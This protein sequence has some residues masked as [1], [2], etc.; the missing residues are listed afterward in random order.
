M[1]K[2]LVSLAGRSLLDW[3]LDALTAA[4]M[5]EI[6][7][8]VGYRGEAVER[9]GLARLWNRSWERSNMVASLLVAADWAGSASCVVSYGDIVYHPGHVDRLAAAP[10]DIAITC[11]LRWRSL[12]EE[13]FARPEE[14]A[15]SLRLSGGR[16]AEIGSPVRELGA[17]DA[18]YMGLLKITPRGFATVR[19]WA[20][21][22]EPEAIARLEMTRLLGELVQ[23]GVEVV[24]VPVE[25]GWCEVD[26]PADLALYEAKL[27]SG[28]RWTHDWRF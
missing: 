28:R 14:D 9:S 19:R 23:S 13:R 4:G 21:R 2:C 12:W 20:A 3:Q 26:Q 7:A 18:Q 27:G 17:V 11:D 15:E 24:A 22:L 8:V 25:G 6:A 5:T 10:G 1:P 16:V